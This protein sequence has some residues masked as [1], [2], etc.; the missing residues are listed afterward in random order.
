SSKTSLPNHILPSH[1]EQLTDEQYQELKQ[2][3]PEVIEVVCPDIFREEVLELYNRFN[4]K[5]RYENLKL[6]LFFFSFCCSSCFSYCY[7]TTSCFNFFNCS[8][9]CIIYSNMIGL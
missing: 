3:I 7:T 9:C 4:E 8:C 6:K 2:T 1:L 5:K